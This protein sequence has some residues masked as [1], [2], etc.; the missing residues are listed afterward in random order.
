MY[1][2][3]YGTLQLEHIQLQ[4]FGEK[5]KGS[6]EILSGYKIGAIQLQESHHTAKTYLIAIY[7][8]N[9]TDRIEGI[10]Y[11]IKADHLH[12]LDTYEGAS[13]ERIEVDLESGKTAWVYRKPI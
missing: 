6:A 4:I 1:L 7:T 12:L 5:L 11:S 10:C 13:Y 2:F 8:G 3:T 9:E